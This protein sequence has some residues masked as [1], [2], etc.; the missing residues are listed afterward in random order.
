MEG[1][2]MLTD[3]LLSRLA[4]VE[5]LISKE[6]GEFLAD[7]AARVPS[8]LAIVEIGS[9]RGKSSCYL[10]SGALH[11][12]G[13]KVWSVDAWTLKGNAGGR[14]GFDQEAVYQD[15]LRH[16]AQFGLEGVVTPV[17]SF[18][19]DAAARWPAD[20]PVG[21][22]YIDGSHTS[23]DVANDWA[24]WIPRLAACRATVVFDDYGTP[25]NPGVTRLVD[26]LRKETLSP[27]IWRNGPPPFMV[28]ESFH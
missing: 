15:F 23:I 17:R 24:N 26:R 28:A 2:R 14:F 5:G 16:R 1:F 13:A 4:A 7:L 27:W 18:S 20:R 12:A 9:Y 6:C 8:D 21:L 22:L 25:R 19:A 3:S 11:G 10:G